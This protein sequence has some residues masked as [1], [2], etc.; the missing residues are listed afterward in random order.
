MH[1]SQHN[2][3]TELGQL[4]KKCVGLETNFVSVLYLHAWL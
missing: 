3:Q 2:K 1:A 4:G